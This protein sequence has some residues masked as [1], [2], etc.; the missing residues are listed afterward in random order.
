MSG[1]V[2][3]KI[4]SILEDL[5]SLPSL[6][7][8]LVRINAMLDDPNSRLPDIGK[9]IAQDPSLS[10]KALRLVNSAFYGLREKANSVERAIIL[11]GIKPTRNLILTASVFETLRCGEQQLIRHSLAAATG[12]RLFAKHLG[13]KSPF[14]GAEEAFMY[15]LLH[16][17][18]KIVMRQYLA[19]EWE[20]VLPAVTNG[21]RAHEAEAKEIGIDHAE[22]GAILGQR[23]KLAD[24]LVMA[25]KGHHNLARCETDTQRRRAACIAVTDWICY[26][27]GY[28][29]IAGAMAGLDETAWGVIGVTPESV[30][31]LVE[32]LR[33]SAG[34]VNELVSLAA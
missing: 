16:D 6:P 21:I 27:A 31:P 30:A 3:A 13:A 7:S 26:E 14:D 1:K 8:T 15:G 29:A 20:R 34:T 11:L 10:L 5:V 25:I 17:V 4:E 9:A 24:D 22:L 33:E 12:A 23:W 32:Q 19:K 18:G 2:N 28:P